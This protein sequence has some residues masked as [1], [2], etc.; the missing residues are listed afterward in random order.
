MNIKHAQYMLTVLQEGSITAA[1]R[2]LYISQPSLSQMIKLVESN[3]GTTIFNRS[4][5]PIT[6]TY[7]GEKY[8]EAAKKIL[9]INA[10][11]QKEIDEINHEDHGTL[12]LGIPVQRAIQVI[13]YVLPRFHALYPHVHLDILESGS[14]KTEAAVLE[15]E[16]DLACLTTTPRHESLH[17]ILIEEEELV[18][19]TSRNSALARRIPSGTPI[20]ITEARDEQFISSKI[21]HSVRDVQDRLFITYGIHPNILLE[22]MSIEVSKRTAIACDAVMICPINYI[23]MSPDLYPRCSIYPILGIEQKRSFYVCHRRDL[24]LT[25]YMK[26]FIRILTELEKPV[27]H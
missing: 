21:G 17:Y 9:S 7:A 13:P 2:K 12:R 4:T 23:E 20:S 25:K 27:L 14:S 26:D 24:Y 15:G 6:L 22:T 16:V 11:L 18:L 8:I 19:L 1:A 5:D 3:L 10:N